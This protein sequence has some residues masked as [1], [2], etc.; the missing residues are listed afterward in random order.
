MYTVPTYF[1]CPGEM[2]NGTFEINV[3]GYSGP[4][5]YEVFDSSSTSVFGLVTANTSTN[6][7]IVTG[8]SAGIYNVVITETASPFCSATSNVIILSPTAALTLVA[9]ETS[10][11]TCDNNSGTRILV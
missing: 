8:M 1:S 9:L 7:E 10:N 2:A 11:V 5:S 4:Y 3:N 6:P